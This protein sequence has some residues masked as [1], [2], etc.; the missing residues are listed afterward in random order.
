MVLHA[1]VEPDMTGQGNCGVR[2]SRWKYAC[3]SLY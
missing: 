2:W 3:M 1:R